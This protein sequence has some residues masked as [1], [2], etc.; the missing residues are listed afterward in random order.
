[1][2]A[3]DD[4]GGVG[5]GG[6]PGQRAASTGPWSPPGWSPQGRR[7]RLGVLG[8]RG[9]RAVARRWP[10]RCR[11]CGRPGRLLHP[12]GLG[13]SRR[14]AQANLATTSFSYALTV[15]PPTPP[16]TTT[17]T[18]TARPPRPRARSPATTAGAQAS[19]GPPGPS[20]FDR[21]RRGRH[22][23]GPVSPH[24]HEQEGRHDRGREHHDHRQPHR[25]V[26]RDPHRQRG[27]GRRRVVEA[28]SRACGS[29][30]PASCR[31]RPARAPSPTSTATP[32]SCATAATRSSSWPSSPPTSRS[33][34]C[35]S[36]ASCPPPAQFDVW[37]HEITM[38]HLHPRERAQAVPRGLPLRR[39]PHGHAGLG[40]GRPVDLLPR[41][42]GDLRPGLAR[43]ADHPAHRQDAHP[44]RRGPPVQRGDA[45]RLPRQRRSTSRPTSSR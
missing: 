28:R 40:G 39:P 36:T 8:Q 12:H 4:P 7:D 5:G 32:G 33:P 27:G 43:Q 3:H 31:R 25:G 6:R 13:R 38:P 23:I 37:Q 19:H 18:A 22:R 35:C 20:R 44:G 15:A 34:T 1:M 10:S 9:A 24:Q 17:T 16:T 2:P 45:L 41:R 30:T 29:T 42:Q 14:P 21:R 26:A 11:P